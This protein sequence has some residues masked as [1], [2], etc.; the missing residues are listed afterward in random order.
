LENTI[1]ISAAFSKNYIY[2]KSHIMF[3]TIAISFVLLGTLFF[4]SSCDKE[5]N[6]KDGFNFATE[7]STEFT[8]LND[9][10]ILYAQD[11]TSEN[12]NAYKAAATA[13]LDAAIDLKTCAE[14]AGQGTA[15]TQAIAD[16]QAEVD[17]LQCS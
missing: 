9:A 15:Y 12:C 1:P 11:P 4:T 3:K 5:E 8:A 17:A 16:T 2:Q 6:C 7:I 14:L 13:Y 10:A